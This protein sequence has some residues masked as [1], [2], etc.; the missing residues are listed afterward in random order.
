MPIRILPNHLI[1]Q[2]A[3]GEVIERPA[4]VVKELLENAIDAGA[5]DIQLQ[6]AQGGL[7]R[8]AVQDNGKGMSAEELSLAVERHATSKLPGDHLDKIENLGFRGE[9]LP[10][11]ASVSRLSILS[12]PSGQDMAMQITVE[13]GK[14]SAPKPAALKSGSLIEVRDLFYATPAR[15]KFMKSPAAETAQILDMTRR[16]ALAYPQCGFMVRDEERILAQYPSSLGD[17]FSKIAA[18]A[19][20]VIGGDFAANSFSILSERNEV[21]IYGLCSLPTFHRGNA[22]MQFFTVNGRPVKDK[23]LYAALRAAYQD[24]LPHGRYPYA[25]LYLDVPPE[26]LDVNVHPAKIELRFRDAAMIRGFVIGS[27]RQALQDHGGKAAKSNTATLID[28]ANRRSFS[29][30]AAQTPSTLHQ[31]QS[32]FHGTLAPQMRVYE[33]P[34]EDVTEY[35]LGAAAAQLHENY[36]L[37]QTQNGVVIV[38]QHA[39]HERIVYESIKAQLAASGIKR[40]ILLIPEPVALPGGEAGVLLEKSAEL[41][42][43]G[44]V[45]EPFGGDTVLV[46]EIPA[47]LGQSPVADMVQNLA[48]EISEMEGSLAIEENL[49]KICASMACYGSVRSGRKL[50]RDEMNALLRQMEKTA[51][52]GQ[53]NHGRPTYVELS[54][55]DIEKLFGRR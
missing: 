43:L 30:A 2:I 40:Q 28:F 15:L 53:C 42:S 10:A 55:D 4:S 20:A 45:I 29:V 47:I 23:Q 19:Q 22:Q 8:I 34:Q 27:I 41:E 6:I 3:A 21:K 39:A 13:G 51:L 54:L 38:D 35:P 12:R 37:A 52:S 26:S 33:T 24:V 14:K 11:I 18:R 16:L 36:I 50:N 1:N 48:H 31:P 25:A 17:I 32:N 5:S 9:A 44:F 49:F 7:A 46:R